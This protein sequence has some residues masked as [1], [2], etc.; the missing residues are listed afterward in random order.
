MS[1]VA[2]SQAQGQQRQQLDG[3]LH[4]FNILLRSNTELEAL[5]RALVSAATLRQLRVR[6]NGL[7]W[8]NTITP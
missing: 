3:E 5:V 6:Q 2:A 1:D 8:L 4:G 7:H